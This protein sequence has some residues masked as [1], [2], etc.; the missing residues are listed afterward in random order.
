M[1]VEGKDSWR[2]RESGSRYTVVASPDQLGCVRTLAEELPVEQIISEMSAAARDAQGR[3]ELDIILVE[4]Y[5]AS[6]L[7]AIEL[8]RADNPNDATRPFD[9][10]L[11]GL[12]AVATD[13]TRIV[14]AATDADIP[15]FLLDDPVALANFIQTH[16][17]PPEG[18]AR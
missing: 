14:A 9:P 8:F 15:V 2:H 12:M 17:C 5:R 10:A 7:P 6:G 1:D 4:G 16:L 18:R 3:S 13:Q 11:P